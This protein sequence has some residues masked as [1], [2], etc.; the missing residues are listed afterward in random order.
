MVETGGSG[1][2]FVVSAPSGTGK[3]TLCRRVCAETP[4]LVYSVSYTTRAP[5]HG[6]EP[7][8]DYFFVSESAFAEM[9]RRGEFL[10]WAK[11]Y[12]HLYGTSRRWV[13]EQL[14]GGLDVIMDVDIQGACQIRKAAFPCH[15]VFLLPPSW[16]ALRERLR[17]RGTDPQEA[18]ELRL[19]SAGEELRGWENFD[20]VI[21]NEELDK[22]VQ[23]LRS[24]V[25]ARRSAKERMALWI[26]ENWWRWDA[27]GP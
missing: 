2:L 16:E 13:E 8:R 11:V 4:R 14:A 1:E 21:V 25:L 9:Q 22:A 7:G 3:T 19:R 23:F 15:L 5:R 12:Q 10:E 26:K 6:E 20:Y 17:G 24:I 18:V 27:G